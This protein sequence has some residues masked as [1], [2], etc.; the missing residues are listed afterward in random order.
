MTQKHRLAVVGSRDF[1]HLESVRMY[2]EDMY[3]KHGENLS[4]VSGGARGVDREAELMGHTLALDV[5]SYRPVQDEHR[6]L[7][8]IHK[9]VNG[10]DLGMVAGRVFGRFASAAFHRNGLIVKDCTQLVAFWDGQSTGTKNSLEL[11][12]ASGKPYEVVLEPVD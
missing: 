12:E 2:I 9:W 11:V 5:V 10:E 6:G 7:W 1:V 8:V 3:K 4:L